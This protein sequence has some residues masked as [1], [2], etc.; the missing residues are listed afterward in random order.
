[1]SHDVYRHFADD[2]ALL[3]VGVS[4]SAV[5]RLY[6]HRQSKWWGKIA[7][8]TI[9]KYQTREEAFRAEK[10]AIIDEAPQYNLDRNPK[11]DFLCSKH[12]TPDGK[13]DR[14]AYQRE[15][16]RKRRAEQRAKAKQ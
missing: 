12:L 6:D 1:M 4:L 5:M 7:K 15:Y 2:G 10:R 3:Y 16:M 9:E 11:A 8:V 14:T 13:F